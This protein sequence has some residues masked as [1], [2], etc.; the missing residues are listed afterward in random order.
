MPICWICRTRP[1]DSSE[2]RFKASDVRM[3]AAQ[4]SQKTPVFL[5]QG[6]ATNIPV[7]SAKA[8]V[9]TFNERICGHCNNQHTQPYDKAWEKL[10]AYL[11]AN[12][13]D[14]SRRGRFDLSKP[15]PGKTRLAALHVH[16]YFVK[17]FGCKLNEDSVPIDL[18]SFSTALMSRTPH[19]D[20]RIVVCHAG[21]RGLDALLMHDSEVHTMRNQHGALHGAVWMY[22]V[23]PVAIKVGWVEAGRP[24]SL[25][26]KKWHPSS[27]SKIVKLSSFDGATE[28]KAGRQALLNPKA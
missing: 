2:H 24:L 14:I 25:V 3:K 7:G 22:L 26:G 18:S 9:L 13:S 1:A 11:H 5:Q 23:S 19:P 20:I 16:L 21:Q 15:F 27:P 4:V 10:S 6:R 12:W 28:P 17:L 8:P